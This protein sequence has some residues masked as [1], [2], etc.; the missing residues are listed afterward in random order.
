MKHALKITL[1]LVSL[2]FI[3]QVVGVTI[4]YKYIDQA[5]STPDQVVWKPLP[6]VA[7]VSLER[8]DV[9]PQYS[10]WYILGA[11]IIGT[12]LVLWIIKHGKINL[13]KMWFFLAVVLCLHIAFGAFIS[14]GFAFALGLLL[15]WLK[16][17][18]PNIF[19][20]NFTEVFLY[21]GLVVIF[22]PILNTL[23]AIILMLLLSVYDMYAVW[24]S[25]HMVH[26]AQFQTKAGIF[27]GMLLPYKLPKPGKRVK[28]K[29]KKVRTAVLGGGDIGFPLI[30]TGVMLKE[31]GL[32]S[33]LTIIPFTTLALLALL[34]F[35]KK[36]KF[37]PAIPFLTA[38]CLIGYAV[39]YG[40][41]L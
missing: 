36:N 30:F 29:L 12:L 15:S 24:Q 28:G 21:G 41:M 4:T 9:A 39:V 7:G 10:V 40:L 18:R 27:A 34:L 20:H 22:V 31:Y 14:S 6:A 3:A 17:Y 32:S 35:G 5:A 33:A 26:M 13:W 37:Y 25:K 16:V 1:L 19:V 2:F 38:G 23:A 8:P 11:I